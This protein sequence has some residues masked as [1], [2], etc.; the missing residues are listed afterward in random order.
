ETAFGWNSLPVKDLRHHGA[1]EHLVEIGETRRITMCVITGCDRAIG[2]LCARTQDRSA[3]AAA[4]NV[5][6][7]MR[8]FDVTV[9]D[10]SSVARRF[11]LP[12][13]MLHLEIARGHVRV[14][15]DRLGRILLA[16]FDVVLVDDL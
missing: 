10:T 9:P 1:A 13:A 3:G 7:Q 5:E 8:V 16:A 2:E 15:L 4:R 11:A 12:A 14:R 6:N